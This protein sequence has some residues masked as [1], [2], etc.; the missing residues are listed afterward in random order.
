MLSIV[1]FILP[2]VLLIL[3]LSQNKNNSFFLLNK[4]EHTLFNQYEFV[5]DI[6]ELKSKF[7]NRKDEDC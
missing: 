5:G 2:L 4:V 7:N 6:N 1:S 3:I